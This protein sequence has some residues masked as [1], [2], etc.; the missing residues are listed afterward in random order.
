MAAVSAEGVAGVVEDV[1][2]SSNL[3]ASGGTLFNV[4][5]GLI[6]LTKNQGRIKFPQLDIF[7]FGVLL[8]I[9]VPSPT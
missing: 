6:D 3:A 7:S 9:S 2:D 4:K 1:A 5:T 8:Q